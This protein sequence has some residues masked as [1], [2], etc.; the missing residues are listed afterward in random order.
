[1]TI[2]A[3]PPE[4]NARLHRKTGNVRQVRRA[5]RLPNRLSLSTIIP[6]AHTQFTD[7]GTDQRAPN[8][9]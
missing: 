8:V 3:K 9:S 6:T 7:S 2:C 5:E 1:L 4:Y